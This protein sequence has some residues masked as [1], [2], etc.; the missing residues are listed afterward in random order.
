[1]R[2]ATGDVIQWLY[3]LKKREINQFKY[4]NLPKELQMRK[5]ILKARFSGLISKV[6]NT[7]KT[8]KAT[9]WRIT[10]EGHT[11]ADLHNR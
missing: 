4:R 2:F 6:K 5:M 3:E 1:M 7:D 11:A 9:T 8:E 10:K